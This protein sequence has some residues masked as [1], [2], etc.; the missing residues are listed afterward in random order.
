MV[1]SVVSGKMTKSSFGGDKKSRTPE[2]VLLPPRKVFFHFFYMGSDGFPA[3]H[4]E[5]REGTRCPF[6]FF[7]P[8]T[9]HGLMVHCSTVHNDQLSFKQQMKDDEGNVSCL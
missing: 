9:Y 5:M 3:V 1:G 4:V 6:C 2:V 8:C 7:D